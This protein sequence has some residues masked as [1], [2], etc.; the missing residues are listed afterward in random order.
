M[1]TEP[2]YKA[3]KKILDFMGSL[4]D[5]FTNKAVNKYYTLVQATTM[6]NTQA[7]E[8][9]TQI[10][11]A[12]CTANKEAIKSGKLKTDLKQG[13]LV[14][15]DKFQFDLKTLIQGSDAE[16]VECIATH[17]RLI[18]YT[19][20]GDEEMKN[21]LVAISSNSSSSSSA[22]SQGSKEDDLFNGLVQKIVNG[23]SSDPNQLIGDVTSQLFNAE[24]L[25]LN[26][27]MSS[28]FGFLRSAKQQMG[29]DESSAP[30]LNMVEMMLNRAKDMQ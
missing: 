10:F 4:K 19:I 16:T 8:K 25:D 23:E 6:D 20:H 13:N 5:T 27:L 9:Q 29:D 22:Q 30:M 3:F 12:F 17:L 7:I 2:N 1:S 15:N 14:F 28:A 24:D 21:Q 11:G 18:S 26:K